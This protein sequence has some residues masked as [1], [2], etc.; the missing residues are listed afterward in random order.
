MERFEQFYEKL[1]ELTAL[2]RELGLQ[3]EMIFNVTIVTTP[4][5]HQAFTKHTK[6]W[7]A[8]HNTEPNEYVEIR[9]S[10]EFAGDRLGVHCMADPDYFKPKKVMLKTK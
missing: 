3:D 5:G 7:E 1:S 10:G 8:R 4:E 6:D 2:K 9:G